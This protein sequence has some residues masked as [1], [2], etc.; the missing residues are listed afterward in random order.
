MRNFVTWNL[1]KTGRKM[2]CAD[3]FVVSFPKS[4][5]TW[6]RVFYF[7]YLAK[8]TGREFSWSSNAFPEFQKIVFTHDRWEHRLLPGW[9]DFIRGKHLVPP[10]ARRKKKIVLIVRDPRDVVVSLHFHLMKRSH[11]FRWKPQS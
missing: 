5:R 3:A 11:V 6:I 4:G 10:L 2:L 1:S 9:W 7:A 8:L